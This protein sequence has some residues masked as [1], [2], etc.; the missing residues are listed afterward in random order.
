MSRA[1]NAVR[2]AYLAPQACQLG[3]KAR[4]DA[5]N[6]SCTARFSHQGE[7]GFTQLSIINAA[8]HQTSI[9]LVRA[10]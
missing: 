1:A 9:T 2:P 6:R 3:A 8:E 4:V 5:Q 7:A 10:P